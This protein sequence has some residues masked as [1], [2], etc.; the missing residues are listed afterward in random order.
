MSAAHSF[1]CRPEERILACANNLLCTTVQLYPAR[2]GDYLSSI[3][4]KFKLFVSQ[5]NDNSRMKKCIP[6]NDLYWQQYDAICHWLIERT[7]S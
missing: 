6:I 1:K 2:A 5:Y 7:I 4:D 3:A